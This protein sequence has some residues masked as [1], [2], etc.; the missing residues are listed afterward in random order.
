ISRFIK[1]NPSQ[2]C[3][4]ISTQTEHRLACAAYNLLEALLDPRYNLPEKQYGMFTLV[5]DYG[6]RL[7]SYGNASGGIFNGLYRSF[8][9]EIDKSIEFVSMGLSTYVTHAYPDVE[10]TSLNIAIDN[11]KESHHS[12]QL[13]LDDNVIV[14][15][16]YVR[17]YHHGRIG[18]SNIG[19]GRVSE[20]RELI[21]KK[22]PE[23]ISG[24]KFYLGSIRNDREW[25]LNDTEVMGLIENLISYALIRDEYREQVKKLSDRLK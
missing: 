14:D 18:I 20:L 3:L 4:D 9:I 25:H 17:F 23:L 11:E 8:I 15:E 5:K 7:L 13:V 12:L 2:Y 24:K 19:S 1:E 6:V 16:D 10:K 22:R 21:A